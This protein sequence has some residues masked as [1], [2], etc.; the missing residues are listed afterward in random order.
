MF[1]G[2]GEVAVCSCQQ[3]AEGAMGRRQGHQVDALVKQAKGLVGS[4]LVL[5]YFGQAAPG[6]CRGASIGAGRRDSPVDDEPADLPPDVGP[7][8]GIPVRRARMST[9]MSGARIWMTK[10]ASK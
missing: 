10:H 5:R 1:G 7:P 9:E 3:C 6:K 4:P 2:A 8:P